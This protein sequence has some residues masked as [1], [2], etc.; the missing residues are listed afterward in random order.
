MSKALR[1]LKEYKNISFKID[2]EKK[3]D[4]QDKREIEWKKEK[5]SLKS[6]GKYLLSYLKINLCLFLYIIVNYF[7]YDFFGMAIDLGESNFVIFLGF[8]TLTIIPSFA[9]GVALK[10]IVIEDFE[11]DLLSL[12]SML[13]CAISLLFF[14]CS[15]F[16]VVYSDSSVIYEML[17]ITFV[18]SFLFLS[19]FLILRSLF[20][21]NIVIFY[22]LEKVKNRCKTKMHKYSSELK[23]LK[24]ELKGDKTLM[25]QLYEEKNNLNYK[26]KRVV[27]KILNKIIHTEIEDD[28]QRIYFESLKK[29]QKKDELNQLQTY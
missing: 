22:T 27:N 12:L 25:R 8:L 19:I 16:K 17:V 14:I 6:T 10:E 21:F 5:K 18:F 26:D 13:M 24:R 20:T 1:W 4:Y 2:E 7:V 15:S 9:Y 29:E 23:K 3:Y 28:I 11:Q